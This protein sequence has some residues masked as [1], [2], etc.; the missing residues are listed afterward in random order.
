M[1]EFPFGIRIEGMRWSSRIHWA[2]VAVA[3]GL[4]FLGWRALWFLTDDAFIHF[5]YVGNSALGY[6]YVWNPPPFRP[7]EG[8]SSFL[9]VVLL[10]LAWRWLGVLP[11][12]SANVLALGFTA[13]SVLLTA[14]IVAKLRLPARLEAHRGTLLALVLLGLVTHRTFLTWSSSGLETAMFDCFVLVWLWAAVRCAERPSLAR[15]A[16]LACAASLVYLTR[17]EGLLFAAASGAALIGA[18]TLGRAPRRLLAGLLGLLPVP[19]HLVWRWRTYGDW[20]PNTYYAK[21]VAPWP[22]AGWHY[23]SSYALEHA[24]WVWALPLLWYGPRLIRRR[25]RAWNGP[26][27][28]AAGPLILDLAVL[29]ELAN[30]GYYTF[31]VGGDSFEYRVYAQL[32]PLA[33]LVLV[34][35]FARVD[36]RPRAALLWVAGFV[37]AGTPIPWLHWNLARGVPAEQA[38]EDLPVPVADALPAPL[39][40]YGERF[41]R[42]QL[43]L[44]ERLLCGR[45]HAHAQFSRTLQQAY[46]ARDFEARMDPAEIQVLAAAAVGVAAWSLPHVAVI[47]VHGLNDHVV[48]RSPVAP[49]ALRQMAHDRLAP[50]AYV[51]AFRPTLILFDYELLERGGR[52][53]PLTAAEVVAIED[54]WFKRAEAG[55]LGGLEPWVPTRPRRTRAPDHSDDSTSLDDPED[56]QLEDTP[57]RWHWAPTTAAPE[58]SPGAPPGAFEQRLRELEALGYASGSEPAPGVSDVTLYD[59]QR[60]HEGLNLYVSGHAPEAVLMDMDGRPLHRWH[61]TFEELWPEAASVETGPGA[62][63]WRRVHLLAGGDLLVVQSGIGLARLDRDSQVVWKRANG[64]HHDLDVRPDGTIYCLTRRARVNPLVHP[65]NPILED[66]IT[67]LGPE[68]ELRRELSLV[69]AFRGSESFDRAFRLRSGDVLHTN[70]IELL[71]VAD[72]E[73][74]G[75]RAG[76]VLISMRENDLLAAVDLEAGRVDWVFEDTFRG[77]H[78]PQL[79]DDGSRLLFDNE[80]LGDHSRILALAPAT[81]ERLWSYGRSE[82][83]RFHSAACGTVQRLPNGNTLIT[84]SDRGRA[85]EVD[86]EKRLVWE[87][88]N[89]NRAGPRGEFI[90]TLFELRRLTQDFETDWI[91]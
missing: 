35:A 60:A 18:V 67:V 77:Q 19:L 84:E 68:G 36:A 32:V 69:D 54:A 25:L 14:H 83:N 41:D 64:A 61:S 38:N 33:L 37:V 52:R 75:L 28:W 90:A 62:Q 16:W 85:F 81:G 51:K 70:S 5:R 79:L 89:P 63:Y 65:S 1:G 49:G 26:A 10:D 7:V 82:A 11:T 13:G 42:E 2:L 6:G 21:H 91:E 12:T 88:F 30:L 40:W 24:L 20:L 17:P 3:L 66:F 39:R 73:V 9:W 56:W 58:T 47:D 53:E 48:A 45:H 44:A 80:G 46:P 87:F 50:K 23:L 15:G 43:W 57:G 76:N 72:V 4:L 59:R 29:T 86:A 31:V 27:A 8:Y 71:D 55:E 34:W 78:D 74:P 22:E